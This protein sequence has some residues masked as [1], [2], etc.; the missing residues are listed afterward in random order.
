V[1]VGRNVS[2]AHQAQVHGPA[3]V[4]DNTFVGMQSLVFRAEVGANCVLE[5]RALVMGVKI[6]TGRYV[7]AGAVVRSQEQADALPL[8]DEHYAFARINEGVL[9]VNHAL[10]EGY[11]RGASR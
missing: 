7:P 10:A 9:H 1:Y 2:I 4:G 11:G 3:T 5:P 6:A 8:I